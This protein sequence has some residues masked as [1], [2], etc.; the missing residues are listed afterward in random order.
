MIPLLAPTLAGVLAPT[1]L[2]CS[3]TCP[4]GLR[5]PEAWLATPPAVLAGEWAQYRLEPSHQGT[6]PGGSHIDASL[7]LTWKS[8]AYAIGDYSASKG[9]PSVAGDGVYVG[10]DD[11]YLRRLSLEDGSLVWEFET[12]AAQTERKREDD[13][14]R[15][16]HGTP[17]IVDGRVYIGAYDGWLYA[18]DEDDGEL[19]WER[20]LGGS[21]GASPVVHN[22][23]VFM[24][25]EYPDPD[26]KVFVLDAQEGCTIY[27]SPYLGDHPHSS[28]TVDPTRGYLV[29]GANNG[30]F[31]AFDFIHGA[32]VWEVWMDGG[33][34][35]DIKSTAAVDGDT[36]YITS[37][38][39]KLHAVDIDSG[40]ERFAFATDQ[41]TMSSPSVHEGVAWFGS[42]DGFLYAIDADPDADYLDPQ[43][44]LLWRY[45]TGD[46]ILSSP[47][48]VP[49]AG[50][51]LI[52]SNDHTLSML[53]MET[54]QALWTQ[55][56]DGRVSS[57]P[58]V[59]GGTLFA[60]DASGATWRWD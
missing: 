53:S 41:D 5:D 4:E 57:V 11:G 55:T 9:S 27:E 56:L 26:G 2:G 42:H 38:D 47:T 60:T 24:A 33:E 17:A 15:G 52:G 50:V 36:V 54:G 23:L 12:R 32:E 1:L 46:R 18:L 44:R 28:A 6:A 19:L 7:T 22:G 16:I 37:W 35:G 29:V 45:G 34:D 39:S 3:R 51:V 43:D 58:V 21:I 25:V 59:T 14:T 40:T 20:Q 8:D 49:E 48:V 13:E 10:I 31:A 30:R